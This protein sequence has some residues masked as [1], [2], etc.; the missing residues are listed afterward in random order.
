[1]S[2]VPD[3]HQFVSDSQ[4]VEAIKGNL[5]VIAQEFDSF[6]VKIQDGDYVSVYG[7]EGIVPLK[8]KPVWKIV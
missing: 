6:F 1:M 3:D 2:S 7:L 5:G 4:D 8:S